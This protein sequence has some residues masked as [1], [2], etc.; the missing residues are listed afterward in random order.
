MQTSCEA[1]KNICLLLSS[2][3]IKQKSGHLLK[4]RECATKFGTLG[5]PVWCMLAHSLHFEQCTNSTQECPLAHCN[6]CT[7][8]HLGHYWCAIAVIFHCLLSPFSL[9]P[10]SFLSVFCLSGLLHKPT[11]VG[12]SPLV[13]QQDNLMFPLPTFSLKLWC[14]L[15]YIAVTTEIFRHH[16]PPGLLCLPLKLVDRLA[17]VRKVRLGSAQYLSMGTPQQ[18][19]TR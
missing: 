2:K 15:L 1:F 13:W 18:Y 6:A 5:N 11:M 14:Q 4:S 19:C 8:M 10:P 3:K 16:I 7:S 17:V 9:L 12:L